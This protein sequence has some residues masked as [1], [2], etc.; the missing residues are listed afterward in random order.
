MQ[1][2]L[3]IW[4]T[5]GDS[6]IDTSDIDYES[7]DIDD[8]DNWWCEICQEH[9]LPKDQDERS[10]LHT[11]LVQILERETSVLDPADAKTLATV[12]DQELPPVYKAA[13]TLLAA[14]QEIVQRNEIQNWFNLD[15]ARAA[16]NE[17]KGNQ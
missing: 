6:E 14:L 2:C 7:S 3:P 15:Q 1:I 16:I 17:A 5:P 11:S 8:S 4:I 13:P 9:H 10:G 12:I